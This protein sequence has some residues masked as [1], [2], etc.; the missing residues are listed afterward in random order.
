[1]KKYQTIHPQGAQGPPTLTFLSRQL[2][3]APSLRSN[4]ALAF[5]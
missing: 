1:M 4:A 5:V 2:S 3:Q